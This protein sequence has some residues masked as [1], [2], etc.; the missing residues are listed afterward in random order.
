MPYIKSED[1]P[2]FDKLIEELTVKITKPGELNYVITKL[3]HTQVEIQG[4]KYETIRSILGDLDGVRL[5]FY[6]RVA[7]P[8]EE[9]KRKMNGDI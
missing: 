9:N 7:A 3:L 4:L 1:R 8:Y 5:E 6:R 2:K